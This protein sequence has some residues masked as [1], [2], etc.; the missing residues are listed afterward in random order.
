MNTNQ[1][2]CNSGEQS[3][4][5]KSDPSPLGKEGSGEHREAQTETTS[6]NAENKKGLRELFRDSQWWQAMALPVGIVAVVI[7][8]YQ[9]CRMTQSIDL[10][11]HMAKIDERAWVGVE[12]I[13]GSPKAGEILRLGIVLKNSGKTFAKKVRNGIDTYETSAHEAPE[14]EVL[15]NEQRYTVLAP[16]QLF[17]IW[18]RPDYVDKDAAERVTK[19]TVH[20]FVKAKITYDDIFGC[21]HWLKVCARFNPFTQTYEM[22]STYNDADGETC[23]EKPLKIK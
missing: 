21:E 17:T 6:D 7:Y 10:T 14:T 8:G 11:R 3:Q 2:Q 9:L 15:V 23:P 18:R 4:P 19:E 13:T 12:S 16:G 20:F 5:E 22:C 1:E